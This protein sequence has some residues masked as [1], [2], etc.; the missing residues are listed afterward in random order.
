MGALALKYAVEILEGAKKDHD[1][2]MATDY[3]TSDKAKLC[4]EGTWEEMN[5]N[6]CNV[7]KPSVVTS[8]A[9]YS[10][11]YTPELPGLGLQAALKG[12]PDN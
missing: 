8:P 9:W 1:I 10:P 3:M 12:T 4:E 2:M 7:F 6:N 11:I 5:K